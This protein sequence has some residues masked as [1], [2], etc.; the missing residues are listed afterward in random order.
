MNISILQVIL[1]CPSVGLTL[2]EADFF[3]QIFIIQSEQNRF[4]IIGCRISVFINRVPG[5]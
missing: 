5:E 2:F 3:S 1:T 4:V